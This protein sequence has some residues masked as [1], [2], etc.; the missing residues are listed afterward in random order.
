MGLTSKE[1]LNTTIDQLSFPPTGKMA[2]ILKGTPEEV[3]TQL[4]EIVKKKKG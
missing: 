2:E 3:M 4:T 1:P